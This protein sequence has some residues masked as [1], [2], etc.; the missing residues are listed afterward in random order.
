MYDYDISAKLPE[1]RPLERQSRDVFS[2]WVCGAPL[3]GSN[4][5]SAV[6]VWMAAFFMSIH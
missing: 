6:K 5:V 1:G 2:R 4:T 3:V